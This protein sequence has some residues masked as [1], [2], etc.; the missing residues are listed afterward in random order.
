M[1]GTLRARLMRP[2]LTELFCKE[3]TSHLNKMRMEHNAQRVA[4][5]REFAEIQSKIDKVIESIKAGID[6]SLIKDEANALQRRKEQLE[7]LLAQTEEAPVYVHPRMGDRYTKAVG[8]LIDSLNDPDHRDASAKLLREL[9]DKIVLTPN[10]D[11][12]ALVAD[13]YG[14]LAGIL[15]VTRAVD[16]KIELKP[17]RDLDR[18][19]VA[20]IQQV[21][22]LI[23][24]AVTQ[25]DCGSGPSQVQLVAGAGF[26][27]ATYRL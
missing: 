19:E 13:L 21:Q 16:G 2:E 11:R 25:S 12:T 10:E 18:D 5:E 1:I 7:V 4:R 23:K 17:S 27:P 20:E 15:Q 26:E 8:D 22:E 3:Y 14:D 24:C 9:I 6:V